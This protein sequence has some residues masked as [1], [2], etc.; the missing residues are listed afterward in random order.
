MELY[1][2]IIIGAG[3]AG[4]N[5]AKALS[6]CGKKILLL[7]KKEVIGPKVCAG[8]LT[9]PDLE[10]LKIP[11]DIL[12][13]K[14]DGVTVHSPLS[15]CDIGSEEYFICTI[16]RKTLGQWQLGKI[17]RSKIEIRTGT[18]V[19][20]IE[21]DSIVLSDGERIGFKY[22]VGADG[23]NSL[24]RKY[25]GLKT[26]SFGIGIQYVIPGWNCEK[27]EFFL[28]SNV[29]HAWYGWIFPHKDFVSVGC[30]ANPKTFPL[31]QLRANFERWLKDM[32][33]DVSKGR[34]EAHSINYDY[35]G[36]KFDNIFLA[37]DA[38]G[39]TSGLTGEGIYPALISG[40]EIAKSILD[41]NYVSRE[42]EKL[43]SLKKTQEYILS[44]LEKSGPLRKVEFELAVLF[45][46]NDYLRNKI[47]K[48]MLI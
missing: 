17:D 10:Y 26:E 30:G 40:E 29:F 2:I 21:K 15:K 9:M 28:D 4:L 11:D 37:G 13:R 38:A 3:P 5:C 23:S 34:Y 8:G 33:I 24:V 39:L 32:R 42:I 46:K 16:D 25:L 19:A 1:D 20:G 7:E 36:Y 18:T 35:R 31:K 45:I 6:E 47:K 41:G 22:L 48:F 43:V 27:L 44:L 14:F 12:G